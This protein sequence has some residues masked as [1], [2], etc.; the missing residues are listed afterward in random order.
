M[1]KDIALVVGK[2]WSTKMNRPKMDSYDLSTKYTM[3]EFIRD[4]EKY[5]NELEKALDKACDMLETY[6]LANEDLTRKKHS[7]K[8]WKEWALKNG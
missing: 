6:D 1:M 4:L 7:Q 2:G 3:C 5:C 8:E